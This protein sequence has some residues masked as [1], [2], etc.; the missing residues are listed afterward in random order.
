MIR[1]EKTHLYLR[2]QDRAPGCSR[3]HAALDARVL[4]DEFIAL[5]ALGCRVD[6]QM[7]A[8]LIEQAVEMRI[9][10]LCEQMVF[11]LAARYVTRA[12]F[13]AAAD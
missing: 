5:D 4:Q 3:S 10:D 2:T 8:C 9:R 12:R 6:D 13:G 11:S 7:P 1:V